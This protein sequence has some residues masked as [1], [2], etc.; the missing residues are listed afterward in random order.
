MT[1]KLNKCG[2]LCCQVV[3]KGVWTDVIVDDNFPMNPKQH[4]PAFTKSLCEYEI[5]PLLLEKCW[6]KLHGNYCKI[7]GG[8]C[9]ETLHDLTGAP[10]RTFF[11]DGRT[12]DIWSRLKEG[13]M[14]DFIMTC[15]S[16]DNN[17]HRQLEKELALTN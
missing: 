5:W 15:G 9:R 7:D 12:D 14:N 2:V 11:L 8:L 4:M 13:E 6:A 1:R 10:T 16:V 3:W 17:E